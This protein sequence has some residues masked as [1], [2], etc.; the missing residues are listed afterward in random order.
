MFLQ[1]WSGQN[2]YRH[3]LLTLNSF[4]QNLCYHYSECVRPM[5]K[6]LHLLHLCYP[7]PL[8]KYECSI[9]INRAGKKHRFFKKK[10]F[11]FF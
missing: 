8:C 9:H 1:P 4:P 11:S 3:M 10:A 5:E 7:T 6:V 2:A